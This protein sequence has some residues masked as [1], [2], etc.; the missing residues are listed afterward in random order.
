MFQAIWRIL[1]CSLLLFLFACANVAAP[2]ELP[3]LP[4]APNYAPTLAPSPTPV[5]PDFMPTLVRPTLATKTDNFES[6]IPTAR[7]RLYTPTAIARIAPKRDLEALKEYQRGIAYVAVSR[8]EYQSEKSKQALDELFATGANYVSVLVTWYQ[9][10]VTSLDIGRAKN[11]PSDADLAFVVDYA[12]AH[13]V[14][15]LLKPQVDFNF[16]PDHWRGQIFFTDEGDWRAW[17]AS[18]KKFILHYAEFAQD[19]SV[20]EFAVG[21]ELLATSTRSA[22]WRAIIRAVRQDYT[23]C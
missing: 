1:A 16:D 19:N 10:D 22:D 9:D 3:A 21:T 6:V 20:E 4:A 12:H 23:A 7:P 13:G 8:D 17:F 14:K 5:P 18:Y 15:V 2:R 11:T